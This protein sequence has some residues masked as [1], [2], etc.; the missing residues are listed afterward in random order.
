MDLAKKNKK[1]L[2]KLKKKGA[3][4]LVFLIWRLLSYFDTIK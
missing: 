2:D 4:L 1:S 3:N